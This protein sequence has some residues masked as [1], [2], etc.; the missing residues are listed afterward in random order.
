MAI[1]ILGVAC[2]TALMSQ[3]HSLHFGRVSLEEGLSQST[4]NVIYQDRTGFMWF[5]TEDGLNRYDG[6]EMLVFKERETPGSLSNSWIWS[7]L[8]DSAGRLWIG[9]KNGGLNLW[10]PEEMLFE[11]YRHDPQ[12]LATLSDDSVRVIVESQDGSLWIGTENGL[13]R[14]DPEQKTFTRVLSGGDQLSDPRVLSLHEDPDGVLW[15]G[16]WTGGLIRFDPA[17]GEKKAYRAAPE[18]P[19]QLSDDHVRVIHEDSEGMLWLGTFEA[20]VIRFDPISETFERFSHDP[21][22]PGS[23]G[24]P[25]VRAVLEDSHGAIWVGT[26]S[27]LDQWIPGTSSFQHFRLDPSDPWS[28]PDNRIRSL[29]QDRNGLLW[30]GTQSAGLAKWNTYSGSFRHHKRISTEPTGLN[31][32]TILAFA[33]TDDALWIG[34]LDGGLNRFDRK[35]L[36]YSH[37][38][39]DPDDPTS[40]SDDRVTSLLVDRRGSLWV[41]TYGGGLNRLDPGSGKYQRFLHSEDDPASLSANGIT[42][43]HEDKRGSLWIGTFRG[44]LNRL[45]PDG[46]FERYRQGAGDQFLTS[47]AVMT[48]L[49]DSLGELWIGTDGGGL[50]QLDLVEGSFSAIRAN[51][52]DPQGLAND[53]IMALHEDASRNLWIGTQAGLH[54]WS[55]RDRAADRVLLERYTESEG[56][57]NNW[58]YGILSD[59]DGNIWLSTNQGLARFDVE[60]ESFKTF[61]TS[62]GLQSKEFNFGAHLASPT[63]TMYFGGM[64]GFN[65]FHPDK[66]MS[67][68]DP[69]PVV[70]TAFRKL[71]RVVDL[72]QPSWQ[73]EAVEIGYRDQVVSF[74]FAALDFTR[75]SSNQYEYQLLGFDDDWIALGSM[76]RATYTNLDHGS[77][78]FRVRAADHDGIWNE[79]GLT[80][81]VDVATPPWKTWWAYGVYGGLVVSLILG[82]QRAQ[83]RRLKRELEYSRKLEEEVQERTQ[84]LQEAALTDP[85]TGLRNRRYLQ[86]YLPEQVE[87]VHRG[88]DARR[89]AAGSGE[90][91]FE[92]EKLLFL[93]IDLDGLKRINDVYGHA[94][95]DAAILR[96]CEL[97]QGACREADTIV[98]LGGDEF[99]VL[100]TCQ[101]IDGAERLSER[102][103]EAVTEAELV[104]EDGT[105][106]SMS[107]SIGFAFHPFCL[108]R[109]GLLKAEHAAN[110]ADRA[111][112]VAKFSGKNMWVGLVGTSLTSSR[113]LLDDLAENLQGLV[114]ENQVELRAT[115]PVEKLCL[116]PNPANSKRTR[117]SEGGEE[118]PEQVLAEHSS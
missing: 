65:S 3:Q 50:N 36:T 58:V 60:E 69:P 55:K 1:S 112:Y 89:L 32:N 57:P 30:I 117:E 34:T 107:C 81:G 106:L 51:K 8:E 113:K 82:Q 109:A 105:V 4:V 45:K 29:H 48:V 116:D 77:Y 27:G 72:P 46:T 85:L 40:L 76:R 56:L 59:D 41:G 100:G 102:I 42:T 92:E 53:T 12:D 52:N 2:A 49:Q 14:L 15:I 87:K 74:E 33:E 43:I 67:D 66:I 28:L 110:I 118:V 9:T 20:G 5:G 71:N 70:L 114:E 21:D 98:R 86:D 7:I 68:L 13:D 23:L 44:G 104:L 90:Q 83:A 103:R 94:A 97:L 64:N 25:R 111:L 93:A 91:A 79:E 78:T 24:G 84:Q 39:H 37:H 95:G 96:M 19:D 80:I 75:P 35:T 73:T 10:H 115:L 108:D 16:T 22:K 38:R 61:D 54:R 63:G 88:N 47:D 26:D 31:S 6:Y 62:H 17:T 11:S 101:E 99:L 18:E